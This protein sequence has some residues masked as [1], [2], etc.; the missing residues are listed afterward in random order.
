M[1]CWIWHEDTVV[2]QKDGQHASKGLWR[3]KDSGDAEV[4]RD[5]KGEA[6]QLTAKA[7]HSTVVRLLLEKGADVDG[8]VVKDE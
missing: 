1:Q 7:G 4:Y 5:T 6:L 2:E 3:I 8:T